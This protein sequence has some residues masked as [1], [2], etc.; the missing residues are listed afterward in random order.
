M[1]IPHN[2]TH[3]LSDDILREI[4]V[5]VITDSTRTAPFTPIQ[6][7]LGTV[8]R[9]WRALILCSP[10]L[11]TDIPLPLKE[12]YD[13]CTLFESTGFDRYHVL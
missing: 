5:Y 6:Y 9:R 13:D 1:N 11:W 4:F 10:L 2:T 8:C 7:I 12:P 3:N